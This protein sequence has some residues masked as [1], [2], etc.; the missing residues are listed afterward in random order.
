MPGIVA[1]CRARLEAVLDDGEII[2][3]V[4]LYDAWGMDA[5]DPEQATAFVAG[6]DACGR[7]YGDAFS[8]YGGVRH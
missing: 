7:W 4:G 5:N 2:P 8:S 6:P 3:I 1:I